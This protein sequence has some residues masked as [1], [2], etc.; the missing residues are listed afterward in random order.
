MFGDWHQLYEEFF[1]ARP[2]QLTFLARTLP[3]KSPASGRS[4]VLDVACGTGAYS[5]AL[6]KLGAQVTGI[7]IDEEM[8]KH[9][10][11]LA[12]AEFAVGTSEADNQLV[13]PE[14]IVADMAELT[15]ATG[16]REFDLVFCIGNSLVLGTNIEPPGQGTLAKR[17]LA[18]ARS[19][20]PDG[21]L[22]VQIVNFDRLLPQLA[23][24]GEIKMPSLRSADQSARLDRAYRWRGSETIEF[25]TSVE[26][27]GAAPGDQP[28]SIFLTP[29]RAEH[30][31]ALVASAGLIVN[32]LSGDFAAGPAWTQSSPATILT[33]RKPR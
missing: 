14:F 13:P 2:A 20:T 27:S 21:T 25:I 5:R 15:E 3:A 22:A 11:R 8:L 32:A 26:A 17:V 30:L 4:T 23:R 9:A 16:R 1:P 12:A 19:V 24:L 10:A 28:G 18:M 7:D 6:A 31:S 29:L 33:A